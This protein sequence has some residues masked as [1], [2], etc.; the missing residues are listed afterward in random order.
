MSNKRTDTTDSD[1]KKAAENAWFALRGARESVATLREQDANTWWPHNQSEATTL[2]WSIALE[3]MALRFP[4]DLFWLYSTWG[5]SEGKAPRQLKEQLLKRYDV[6]YLG[7]GEENYR[8]FRSRRQLS[9]MWPQQFMVDFST[10]SFAANSNRFLL[11]MESEVASSHSVDG[12]IERNCGYAWDYG[13]LLFIESPLRLFVARV[14]GKNG[15][16]GDVR[17]RELLSNLNE[18]TGKVLGEMDDQRGPGKVLRVL[19]ILGSERAARA[20]PIVA[21]W[22]GKSF[23][24]TTDDSVG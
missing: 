10:Y 16:T 21:V 6:R 9:T 24:T 22:N 19:Y 12:R 1:L 7:H 23:V 3:W 15:A 4:Q 20:L 5:T 18:L 11:T 2:A 17:R 8:Q 14:G 13:K